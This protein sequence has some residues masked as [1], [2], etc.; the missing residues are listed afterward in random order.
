MLLAIIK[1]KGNYIIFLIFNEFLIVIWISAMTNHSD[2]ALDQKFESKERFRAKDAF[3][4]ECG[5]IN[6]EG[7]S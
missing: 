5:A 4:I 7:S 1:R 6:I 3:S 2:I